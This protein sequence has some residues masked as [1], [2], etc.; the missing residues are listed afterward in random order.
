MAKN[1]EMNIKTEEGYEILYP[2]GIPVVGELVTIPININKNISKNMGEF[3][4]LTVSLP[5]LGFAAAYNSPYIIIHFNLQNNSILSSDNEEGSTIS[6][7][8]KNKGTSVRGGGIGT[9]YPYKDSNFISN[10][11]VLKSNLSNNFPYY[12][13]GY[14]VIPENM[15]SYIYFLYYKAEDFSFPT[16]YD[17][18]KIDINIAPSKGISGILSLMGEIVFYLY[19]IQI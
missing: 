18:E 16:T 19:Y 17:Y 1:I 6:I 9:F 13:S 15:N 14:Y 8:V 3:S 4:A 11:V 2:Q 12:M 10:I 5:Q 7:H